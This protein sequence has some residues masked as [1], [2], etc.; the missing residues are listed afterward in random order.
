MNL[1]VKQRTVEF[2]F[3]SK[4]DTLVNLGR[5]LGLTF[6]TRLEHTGAGGA[7]IVTAAIELTPAERRARLGAVLSQLLDVQREG[8]PA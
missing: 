5:E 3:W 4:P 6:P 2:S 1:K 8:A 7:P